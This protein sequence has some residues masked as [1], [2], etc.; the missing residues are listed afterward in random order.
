[1][2]VKRVRKREA[3]VIIEQTKMDREARV[4]KR[5]E[6]SLIIILIGKRDHRFQKKERIEHKVM[7]WMDHL[8]FVRMLEWVPK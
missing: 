2:L 6:V 1:M 3:E 4:I 5:K 8:R 7:Y